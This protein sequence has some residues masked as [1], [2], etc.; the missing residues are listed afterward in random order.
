MEMQLSIKMFATK[1]VQLQR[2][3]RQQMLTCILGMEGVIL[4]V[5]KK[6]VEL[7]CMMESVIKIVQ[8]GFQQT[9]PHLHI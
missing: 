9:R 4:T 7:S 3:I 8:Q 2:L 5:V 6:V 1:I